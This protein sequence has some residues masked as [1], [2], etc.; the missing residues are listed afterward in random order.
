M[1]LRVFPAAIAAVLAAGVLAGAPGALAAPGGKDKG[2]AKHKPSVQTLANN[3]ATTARIKSALLADKIAPGMSINV[4]TN[5]GVVTLR[6]QVD[7][8]DQKSRAERI[9]KKEKGVKAVKNK[10]TVKPK[11]A[12]PS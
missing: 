2:A 6:G 3:A 10:L 7:N 11:H 4:D 8:A 5:G 12:T 9:A 1:K